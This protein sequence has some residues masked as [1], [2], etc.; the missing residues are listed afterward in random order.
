MNIPIV[1]EQLQY[2]E[3]HR[4]LRDVPKEELDTWVP[5]L[6]DLLFQEAR[7]QDNDWRDYDPLNQRILRWSGG[8]AT[9]ATFTQKPGERHLE[10]IDVTHRERYLYRVHQT[11][12]G[13]D[14]FQCFGDR[15]GVFAMEC[16]HVDFK[17]SQ[18]SFS[19]Y[20]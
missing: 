18:N 1:T 8:T 2:F 19:Q 10:R 15:W 9:S 5:D 7:K 14:F 3:K 16:S 20:L 12:E 13:L 11:A 17:N 4:E 6:T